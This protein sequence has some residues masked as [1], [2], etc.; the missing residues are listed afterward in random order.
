MIEL[1]VIAEFLAFRVLMKI[2]I[3]L[4]TF[5]LVFVVA[6]FFVFFGKKKLFKEFLFFHFISFSIFVVLLSFM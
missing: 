4:E 1:L 6:P 2:E 3:D 5:V